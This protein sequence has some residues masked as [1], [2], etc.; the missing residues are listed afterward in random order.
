MGVGRVLGLAT[1]IIERSNDVRKLTN[2]T[3]RTVHALAVVAMLVLGSAPARAQPNTIVVIAPCTLV[4][5]Y[6]TTPGAPV[7]ITVRG[8]CGVP[9]NA[10]AVFVRLE[11]G[12]AAVNG[13]AWLWTY[14]QPRPAIAQLSYRGQAVDEGAVFTDSSAVVKLGAAVAPVTS[15]VIAQTTTAVFLTVVVEAYTVP[16]IATSPIP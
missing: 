3:N 4:N 10:V 7:G 1:T 9:N 14:G 16:F 5:S 12:G 6:Y 11:A 13:K 2:W 15:N 8:Q